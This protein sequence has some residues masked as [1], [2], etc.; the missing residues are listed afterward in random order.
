MAVKYDGI[1]ADFQ[2]YLS[3]PDVDEAK[4][5]R[6]DLLREHEAAED[7]RRAALSKIR[8]QAIADARAAWNASNAFFAP[9]LFQQLARDGAG[10]EVALQEVTAVGWRL[11]SWQ[12]IGAPSPFEST[13]TPDSDPIRS[14]A[15]GNAS[16]S[17]VMTPPA[18]V[19]KTESPALH[20]GRF[21]SRDL[22]RQPVFCTIEGFV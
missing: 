1:N 20:A 16:R 8:E 17:V 7:E 19:L 21:L 13:V 11:D 6:D 15:R 18:P 22:T 3:R 2:R 10:W 4:R 5:K 12:V 14:L 9:V